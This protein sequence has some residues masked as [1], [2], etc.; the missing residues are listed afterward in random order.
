MLKEKIL[1]DIKNAMKSGDSLTTGVLRMVN[2]A[3]KNKEIE[4]FAKK[5]EITDEEVLQLLQ[6]EVK[7][8]KEAAEV[9]QKGDRQELADKE[10]A[11]ME[12]IKKY[13]PQQ[14]SE[15]EISPIIDR[16]ISSATKKELGLIMKEATKELKGKADMGLVSKLL[17][18]KLG[19]SI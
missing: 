8:R 3:I 19:A 2:A 18:Q 10:L 4:L 5:K 16:L 17:K 7:K 9:Y 1:E 14:L 12:V 11:E 6:T 15:A 13:M